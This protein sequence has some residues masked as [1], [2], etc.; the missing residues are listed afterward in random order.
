LGDVTTVA[1]IATLASTL[2]DQ[3]EQQRAYLNVLALALLVLM[4]PICALIAHR[5]HN[6]RQVLRH[7]WWPI[8]LSMILSSLAGM[9]LDKAV[10]LFVGF[11]L[12]QPLINGVGGNLAAIQAS[13]ISTFLHRTLTDREFVQKTCQAKQM[14]CEQHVR[15]RKNSLQEQIYVELFDSTDPIVGDSDLKPIEIVAPA[16][17]AAAVAAHRSVQGETSVRLSERDFR[18]ILLDSQCAKVLLLIALPLHVVYYY[19]IVAFKGSYSFDNQTYF[20]PVYVFAALVQMI[21]L[22]HCARSLVYWMWDKKI[23]P[24]NCSIPVLTAF[25]DLIGTSLLAI[26]FLLLNPSRFI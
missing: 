8:L 10:A 25:G 2:F 24:D 15:L 20:L 6:T 14:L 17:A 12:V 23:N 9:I 1:L 26:G 11:A 19:T 7:G 22:L 3:V 21:T 4:T 16:A 18:Q 13:R 5:N